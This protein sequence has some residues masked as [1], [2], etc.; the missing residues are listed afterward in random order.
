MDGCFSYTIATGCDC[1]CDSGQHHGGVFFGRLLSVWHW[2]V[3]YRA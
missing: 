3:K 1:D 2:V